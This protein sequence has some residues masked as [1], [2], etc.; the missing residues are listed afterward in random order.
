VT[1]S[2]LHTRRE[3]AVGTAL[4]VYAGAVA[5]VPDA[6]TKL[7]LCLPL[8]VPLVFW[9][10]RDPARWVPVFLAA[11]WLLP[12]LPFEA[13]NTGPHIAVLVAGAGLLSG[14][15]RLDDWRFRPDGLSTCVLALC[16][17]F[18]TSL[19]FALALSGVPVAAAST[20][21]FLLFGISVYT[22]FYL[23]DGPGRDA[24]SGVP[25]LSRTLFTVAAVSATLACID[26]YFQFPAP[27]GYG[28]QFVWLESGV[29][30]RAQGVFY[31]ASTLGNLCAFFLVMVAVVFVTRPRIDLPARPLLLLGAIP[32]S[33]AM[34]LSY[35]RASAVNLLTSVAVLLVLNRR[36]IRWMTAAATLFG[37]TVAAVLALGWLFPS[38]FSSYL[39]RASASVEYF[40]E[41]PNAVLSGRLET[42]IRLGQ[43]LAANPQ[44][45][46]F[47]TGYKTLAY[48]TFTGSPL[49]VD[50]T[51][52][53]V[54]AETGLAGLTALLATNAAIIAACYRAAK[55]KDAGRSFPGTWMLCFWCGQMVQM[56]SA[57]L[58]TYWR[59]LPAY[60]VLLALATRPRQDAREP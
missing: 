52:L 18:G 3:V 11:A 55:S 32:L 8:C 53:S 21:R 49:I 45:L 14:L 58:L 20:A 41:S 33:V 47:G 31:E 57:D 34:V 15:L 40:F 27:A 23:R 17:C 26:F 60:F 56:L 50:N 46:F 28:A 22:F 59:T 30:R 42:W 29:F 48:S 36:R 43:Y 2:A 7:A 13:G 44:H 38:F 1:A 4:G 5:L 24:A 10:V 25:L 9:L 54:L 19:G 51:Y 16:V 37:V 35:S 6:W 12:P 39:S